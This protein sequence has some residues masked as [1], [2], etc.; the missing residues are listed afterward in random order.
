M[1]KANT[2]FTLIT[3][4]SSGIGAA[5]ADRM[6]K[7]G[8]NLILVARNVE[9]LNFLANKLRK[10]RG[11]NVEVISTD[12]TNESDISRIEKILSTDKRITM[13][14][15]NAGVGAVSKLIESDVN[16]MKEM[17][18]LNVL[19]LTRLTYAAVP[20]FVE[21][22]KG[23]IINIS[24][25]AAI[26]PEALNGVYGGT[27]AFV[28]A[29]TNSLHYE[30]ADAGLR[31]QAVLPGVIATEFW[32]TAGMPVA[33]LPKDIVMTTDNLVDASL[34]GLDLGEIITIPSLP[35]KNEWDHFEKARE[36]MRP[37][38]SRTVPAARYG[39]FTNI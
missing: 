39:E 14:I 29:L 13:L 31:V 18:N 3:G 4:A 6:A 22:G 37:M 16:K 32:E 21:K 34:R 1:S 38:L 33:N 35:D 25:I 2:E 27:K 24:S 11:V 23:T 15:N 8:S 26:N 28:L 17:I 7:R 19:A 10:E 9:R 30:L 5:Y 36:K 12:L 20:A